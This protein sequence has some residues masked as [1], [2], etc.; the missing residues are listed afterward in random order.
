MDVSVKTLECCVCSATR[1]TITETINNG[2]YAPK[3][4][5]AWCSVPHWLQSR[6][7]EATWKN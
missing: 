7:C 3:V 5:A 4:S 6:G 1:V 2:S